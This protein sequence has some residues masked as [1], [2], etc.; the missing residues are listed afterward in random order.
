M[1]CYPVHFLLLLLNASLTM[2]KAPNLINRIIFE[3]ALKPGVAEGNGSIWSTLREEN[4]FSI[5][6]KISHCKILPN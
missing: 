1:K 6:T 5:Y 4:V 3:V 2:Q